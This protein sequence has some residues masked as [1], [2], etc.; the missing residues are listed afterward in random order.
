M[1]IDDTIEDMDDLYQ[2]FKEEDR[3]KE[4]KKA[5]EAVDEF[6]DNKTQDNLY[7]NVLTP[8]FDELYKAL[9]SGL[10]DELGK[11]STKLY[12]KK[13]KLKKVMIDALKKFFEKAMPSVLKGIEGETDP[14]EVYKILTHHYGE[15]VGEDIN[16]ILE[17]YSADDDATIGNLKRG[18]KSTE[19]ERKGGVLGK[20]RDRYTLVHLSHFNKPDVAHYVRELA[21]GKKDQFKGI[22][23]GTLYTLDLQDLYQAHVGIHKGKW[24]IDKD[25]KQPKSPKDY[26]LK[27]K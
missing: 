12:G 27:P 21:E 18:I 5:F 25:T 16:G 24:G 9:E 2:R 6:M 26:G 13:D 15:V 4:V 3:H 23:H 7:N 1:T 20:L 11:D 14:E 8:A 10:K 22:K 19:N 17:T